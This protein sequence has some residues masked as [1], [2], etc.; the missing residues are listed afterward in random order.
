MQISILLHFL[1]HVLLESNSFYHHIYQT[2]SVQN[3]LYPSHY[4]HV[5]K[6]SSLILQVSWPR[7]WPP[8]TKK[9]QMKQ[10]KP[11]S[12]W[13]MDK[14]KQE[15]G[16]GWEIGGKVFQNLNSCGI[17]LIAI[18]YFFFCNGIKGQTNLEVPI[19]SKQWWQIII[20]MNNNNNNNNQNNN[21][22]PIN[23]M[24]YLQGKHTSKHGRAQ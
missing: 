16:K 7:P 13:E 20:I 14:Q 2:G 6:P 11:K 3:R 19:F 21:V 24:P 12:T 23:T 5:E 9:P 4:R 15:L 17:I 22:Q 1:L 18:I 10:T 8:K